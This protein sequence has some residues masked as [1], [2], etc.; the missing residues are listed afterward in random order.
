M[1]KRRLGRTGL[2]VSI[3]GFG[4]I[5][6]I[7]RSRHDAEKTVRYAYDKGIN[8]FDTARAYGDGEEKIGAALKE[9]RDQVILA[10]KTH[11][12]TKEDVARAGL[13]QS[14]RN[15]HTDRIDIVQLHGIDNEETLKKTMGSEGAL[16]ALQKARSQGKIDYIGISGHNP[17]VLVEAIKTWKFDTILVPLNILERRATEELI[18]LAK[19]L[20]I[21]VIIMKAMG[22]CGAPMYYPQRGARFLGKPELDWPD[23]SEFVICF[24]KDG[25]ERAQCSL[26]FVLA[27][28]IDTVIPGLRSM[29]EVDYAV[30]V[31][32]SFR[33]LT[34]EEK[35]A[36]KFE[37]LPPE[38]FCRECQLCMPCP[39]GVEITTI[40][41]WD[42]YYTFY[43][44][45]KWTRD[46]YPKL[47][48][49]VNSC[50]ECGK[51]EEKCPY[52]LPVIN[53]LKETEKRLNP[54]MK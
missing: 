41:R 38:P 4:G 19:K 51:C 20:D 3:I 16:K 39:E 48:T 43:G 17:H 27:H 12:R 52:S 26:R 21:G 18:P 14:L 30:K 9:V 54:Y 33:K 44:I 25:L 29:E 7:A 35:K 34:L 31:A 22:G 23:P 10:T 24:G 8:Y 40:L 53:M 32:T 28:N 11:Q 15:L 36:Y 6:I 2:K 42:L 47:R 1:Q 13:K 37:E 45:M 5:P 49:R 46:Q 50:T